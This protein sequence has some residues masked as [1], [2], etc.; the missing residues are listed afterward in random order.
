MATIHRYALQHITAIMCG[1][2]VKLLRL[3]RSSGR[4]APWSNSSARHTG[5]LAIIPDDDTSLTQE[6]QESL[7]EQG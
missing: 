4:G 3:R 5:A 1:G 7:L 2:F 6:F